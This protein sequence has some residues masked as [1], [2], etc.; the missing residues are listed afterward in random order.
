MKFK[1]TALMLA[2]ALA[3]PGIAQVKD[4]AQLFRTKKSTVA[5]N[6]TIS[7][8]KVV[9]VTSQLREDIPADQA[10]ITFVVLDSEDE[11]AGVWGDGSGYQMLLDADA[12]AYGSIIPE[13]GAL[14][15]G[16]DVDA[17]TYAEFEYKIPE[18]A[19]GAL[20]TTNMIVSGTETAMI[21]AGVYDWCIT[22]PTPGD[23]MWIASDQGSVGGR[24][25]DF[26]FIGGCGYTFTISLNET[27]GNDQT[28]LEIFD[29]TAPQVPTALTVNPA[30]T[31]ADAAWTAGDNNSAWNLRYREYTENPAQTITW[32]FEKDSDFEGWTIY[33]ADGD[34]Y[35][36]W[37]NQGSSYYAHS[38]TGSL[39][40]ASYYS[41]S[42]TP[43]NWLI[44]D[45]YPMNGTL[46]FWAGPYSSYWPDN[47]GA[48]VILGEDLTTESFANAVQVLDDQAPSEWTEYTI[49]LSQFEGQKGH[50]AIRHYNCTNQYYLCVDDITLNIPGDP[51]KEWIPVE[52]IAEAQYQ[53]TGLTPETTYE[54]Q[55]QGVSEDGRVS[56]W[57]EST[58]FTTL[59][60]EPQEEAKFYIVGGFN[61]WN[62]DPPLEI[63]EEGATFD[64]V[65]DPE[66]VESKEFKIL[67]AGEN[68]WL[69]LGGVDENG[70]GYFEISEG[71]MTSGTEI[72]L[73]DAGANFR[74]PG[75]GNYTITL[76]K[77]ESKA[78]VE[79]V[80][81]VV[82][83]NNLTPT[84]VTDV[85]S[86][87]VAGVKYVNIAGMES[88]VPFDGVNI[89]VTTY[90]D[91][92]KAA[93][94]VIK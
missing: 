29:P 72:T 78:P 18:A 20:A 49:D 75:S 64:V 36:W 8:L 51:L 83:Q 77:E 46:T 33:D 54:V 94:K 5:V 73:D 58:L 66:D 80:K 13:T 93:A 39:Y 88:N 71:M 35:N 16:G 41:G 82:K 30:A 27:T 3:I 85:N 17:A 23:R 79:G 59:A 24:A 34:G 48:F 22:N 57:T 63:T 67:T 25:D 87:T 60:E 9:K 44:S 45:T 40:S 74:L 65:E 11:G 55:V 56:D 89:V 19:D 84:A 28:D 4:G 26:E 86:K 52:N 12:N 43:D 50:F 6:P 70:V 61:G 7:T 68:D 90:T 1:F 10:R 62:A 53:I 81:I 2:V 31:K 47:F 37:A 32:D 69:W 38:G 42:L 15:T 76:A 21:P 14:T 91:G 92:T